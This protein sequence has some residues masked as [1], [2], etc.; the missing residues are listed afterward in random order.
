MGTKC[1][2]RGARGRV[3]VVQNNVKKIE[4]GITSGCIVLKQST[5]P[6]FIIRTFERNHKKRSGCLKM[7][8]LQWR[9][10]SLDLQTWWLQ[11]F[12]ENAALWKESYWKN[13]AQSPLSGTLRYVCPKLINNSKTSAQN[14]ES[15][16]GYSTTTMYC[17]TERRTQSL[18]WSNLDWLF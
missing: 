17:L 7:R 6:V 4:I 13:S 12:L 18:F 9:R 10:E 5:K 16:P 1:F 3:R 8:I 11:C 15:A 14:L 2:H